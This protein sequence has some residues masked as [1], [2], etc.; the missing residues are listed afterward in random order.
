[1]AKLRSAVTKLRRTYFA[2]E[3]ENFLVD[4]AFRGKVHGGCRLVGALKLILAF[5][6]RQSEE[7]SRSAL[8][9]KGRLSQEG[10]REED[11]R[12]DKQG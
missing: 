2:V 1:M 5:R 8:L 10:Q 3:H 9:A 6:V 7:R 12:V 11:K 4:P